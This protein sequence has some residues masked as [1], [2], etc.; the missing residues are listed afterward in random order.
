MNRGIVSLRKPHMAKSWTTLMKYNR[1]IS[2]TK[3]A[4]MARGILGKMAVPERAVPQPV[5]MDHGLSL[6]EQEFPLK[7][8]T[9]G[10]FTCGD[11]SSGD[12]PEYAHGHASFTQFT[13]F[14]LLSLCTCGHWT[15]TSGHQL[16]TSVTHSSYLSRSR[17]TLTEFR[18]CEWQPYSTRSFRALEHGE[19]LP[20]SLV[21]DPFLCRGLR[22]W[23]QSV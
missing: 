11:A 2:V 16:Q 6:V 1:G 15:M 14:S 5:S 21:L 3:V 23:S 12:I 10:D 22:T 8:L 13:F 20:K 18:G 4:V 17:H 9:N 7:W 19:H